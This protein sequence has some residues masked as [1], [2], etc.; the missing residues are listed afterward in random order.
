MSSASTEHSLVET[1]M[2]NVWYC[3]C[4]Q[5]RDY[6]NPNSFIE[7]D[8][9]PRFWLSEDGTTNFK[10]ILESTYQ[11]LRVQEIYRTTIF[12]QNEDG[13]E[14]PTHYHPD[15]F[16]PGDNLA[17]DAW[18]EKAHELNE[19]V[20]EKIKARSQLIQKNAF[21][22]YSSKIIRHDMHSG[23]NTYLPRG[24]KML[25]KKLDENTIKELK[26]Q[27]AITM[28]EKGLKHTQKVY[29]GVYAFTN[30]VK[31]TSQL[32]TKE[33]NLKESL[34]D[35]L[36]STGYMQR[37][38]VGE[39]PN[40]VGNESLLC[41]AIDNLIRNGLKYNDHAINKQH[42]KVY[43]EDEWLIVEDNGRGITQDEFEELSLP[44]KRKENQVESGSGLGLN[45]CIAIFNE[46]RYRIKVE[47]IENGTK[48][49]VGPIQ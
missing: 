43:M 28:L 41:T 23:I 22:E 37:V 24:L 6:A 4:W 38:S 20:L 21:L 26:L 8:G 18:L 5:P 44:Y 31:E 36:M 27:S 10:S 47:K 39:L 48:I 40:I 32:D 33:F 25:M 15:R 19:H 17:Y 45:I 13:D 1:E 2:K 14:L 49:A 16:M 30:L 11:N 46:H 29:H 35:Y 42:V 9:C 34:D 7:L 3:I 12:T